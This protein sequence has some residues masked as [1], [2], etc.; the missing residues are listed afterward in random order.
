MEAVVD[1]YAMSE[2][3]LVFNECIAT[4]CALELKCQ[5]NTV[6]SICQVKPQ[7]VAFD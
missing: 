4:E 6:R 5:I 1:N 7:I 3:K 2:F